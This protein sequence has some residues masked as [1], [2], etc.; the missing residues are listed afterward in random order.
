MGEIDQLAVAVWTRSSLSGLL[1][2]KGLPL[3]HH[4]DGTSILDTDDADA[5]RMDRS[6]KAG[7]W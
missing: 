7:S 1:G 3:F 5:R 2:E 4:V 6:L